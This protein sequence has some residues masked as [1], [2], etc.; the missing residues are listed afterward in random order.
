MA[1]RRM[2]MKVAVNV[3]RARQTKCE[4]DPHIF[5]EEELTGVE[6]VPYQPRDDMR[7]SISVQIY[8]SS[9]MYR[10]LILI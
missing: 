5:N 7:C 3:G 10:I 8:D 2:K 9:R 4:E 1:S 6:L